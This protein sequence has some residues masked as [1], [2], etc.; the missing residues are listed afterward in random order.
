M[1]KYQTKGA[2]L[3]SLAHWKGGVKATPHWNPRVEKKRA[4][5][6]D[7]K[8]SSAQIMIGSHVPTIADGLKTRRYT[9]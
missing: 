7:T 3:S 1:I 9:Y 8:A 6:L 4:Q 5:V 2:S